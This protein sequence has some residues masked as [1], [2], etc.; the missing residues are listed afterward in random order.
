MKLRLTAAFLAAWIL[1]GCVGGTTKLR[2]TEMPDIEDTPMDK[3]VAV[4]DCALGLAGYK[5]NPSDSPNSTKCWIVKEGDDQPLMVSHSYGVFVFQDL[6]P[7]RYAIV[8]VE[9]NATL[10]IEDARDAADREAADQTVDEVPHDCRFTY[11]FPAW[12]TPELTFVAE[13]GR[14]TYVGVMTIAEPAV[15]EIRHGER[16]PTSVTRED[17]A[18]GVSFGSGVSYEKRALEELYAKNGN[19]DWGAIIQK[20]LEELR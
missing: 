14:V 2:Y 16:P 5:P 17:Y 8:K 9:W 6:D 3:S 18:D 13:P 11:L 10:W 7:G 1:A 4:I 15:F 12:R 20:R 19:G